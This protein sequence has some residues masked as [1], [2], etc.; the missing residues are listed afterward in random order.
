MLFFDPILYNLGRFKMKKLWAIIYIFLFVNY[1]HGGED[2]EAGSGKTL[3]FRVYALKTDDLSVVLREKDSAKKQ[4]HHHWH[5]CRKVEGCRWIG[6]PKTKTHPPFWN[7]VSDGIG[8]KL[9]EEEDDKNTGEHW[10]YFIPSTAS[11]AGVAFVIA[12]GQGEYLKGIKDTFT[13]KGEELPNTVINSDY[14]WEDFGRTI[15]SNLVLGPE[16]PNDKGTISGKPYNKFASS[17]K[18]K[19]FCSVTMR[20]T[21]V[22]SLLD[23]CV[24]LWGFYQSKTRFI[25]DELERVAKESEQELKLVDEGLIEDAAIED[26]E[27]GDTEEFSIEV[28]LS[29]DGGADESEGSE[30]KESKAVVKLFG[31]YYEF[32]GLQDYIRRTWLSVE[33]LMEGSDAVELPS[34]DEDALREDAVKVKKGEKEVV[35]WE[36]TYN[37]HASETGSFTLLDQRCVASGQIEMCDLLE[38]DKNQLVHVKIGTDSAKLN[39]LFGQG[40]ASAD[41]LSKAGMRNQIL[42]DLIRLKL[43]E[44][45]VAATKAKR[46]V[47]EVELWKEFEAWRAEHKEEIEKAYE[48]SEGEESRVAHEALKESESDIEDMVKAVEG[49]KDA[50]GLDSEGIVQLIAE[51]RE[52]KESAKKKIEEVKKQLSDKMKKKGK[53]VADFVVV[54]TFPR[55][56]GNFKR[57]CI[58]LEKYATKSKDVALKKLVKKLNSYR[59]D[60][61]IEHLGGVWK[62]I[63]NT[64][65]SFDNKRTITRYTSAQFLKEAFKAGDHESHRKVIVAE[66]MKKYRTAAKGKKKKPTLTPEEI[67]VLLEHDSFEDLYESL[68]TWLWNGEKRLMQ[69]VYA[70][71][72]EGN[73][74]IDHRFMP[75][76]ARISLIHAVKNIEALGDGKQFKVVLKVIDKE[77]GEDKGTKKTRKTTKKK[78]KPVVK[79][80]KKPGDPPPSPK[81]SPSVRVDASIDILDRDELTV[82]VVEIGRFPRLQTAPSGVEVLLPDG[83]PESFVVVPA[84]PDGNCFFH[85]AF[86]QNGVEYTDMKTFSEEKRKAAVDRILAGEGDFQDT[87]KAEM[88]GYYREAYI[89]K[90]FGVIPDFI[91][92]LIEGSYA[93]DTAKAAVEKMKLENPDI[94]LPNLP[95][96]NPVNANI[97]GFITPPLMAAY[98]QKYLEPT[99]GS[100]YYVQIPTGTSGKC[101]AAILAQISDTKIQCFEFRD[102]CL[103][104][105]SSVGLDGA[106]RLVRILRRGQHFEGLYDASEEDARKKGVWQ[107]YQNTGITVQVDKVEETS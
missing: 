88:L 81:P 8:S 23:V 86:T 72:N 49:Y 15:V 20:V 54:K 92:E 103:Q 24:S 57:F 40:L 3:T 60:L 71:V 21:G 41:L 26:D 61:I 10:I 85:A 68:Y 48:V 19:D 4:I 2:E 78:T 31:R 70:I 107:A 105:Q 55:S 84:R 16:G 101:F 46:D 29:K 42:I 83:T 39:H 93:Y 104:Y 44:M 77:G 7:F 102:G 91:R 34:Y 62:T 97:K 37:K 59:T 33:S 35:K 100:E 75:L 1:A 12:F 74:K 89:D 14:G 56:K 25:Y 18:G 53:R 51:I 36:E 45:I 66:M 67:A 5:D 22:E 82:G 58:D 9:I 17:V 47:V 6:I 98:L 76:G 63:L 52:K 65:Q 50:L 38:V 11:P 27:V 64:L 87:M 106:A 28:P 96:E 99:R 30:K 80:R 79:K 90:K 13:W 94:P 43:E 95:A 69:V 73:K 32:E